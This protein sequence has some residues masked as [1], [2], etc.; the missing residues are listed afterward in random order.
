MAATSTNATRVRSTPPHHVSQK[1]GILQQSSTRRNRWANVLRSLNM[2]ISLSRE[3]VYDCAG[4]THGASRF[5]KVDGP[6]K[7]SD[8]R[9]GRLPYSHFIA[10]PLNRS[11][12][13]SRSS[14]LCDA[15]CPRRHFLSE[16]LRP[17]QIEF[18]FVRA[19]E[20]PTKFKCESSYLGLVHYRSP[21]LQGQVFESSPDTQLL[22]Q[23]L[24]HDRSVFESEGSPRS[25]THAL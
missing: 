15:E 14:A 6:F 9:V 18:G 13:C 23:V 12:L 21:A 4:R 2:E 5:L 3:C 25:D 7:M 17:R 10:S 19:S 16:D 24:G 11:R 1:R 8:S 20:S 22:S